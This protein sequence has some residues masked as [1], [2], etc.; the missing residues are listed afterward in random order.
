MI[1][2]ICLFTL[3]LYVLFYTSGQLIN[4][5]KETRQ[6]DFSSF[7]K[8]VYWVRILDKKGNESTKKVIKN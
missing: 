6:L 2:M 3:I 8:G 4:A 7:E 5:S 1:K